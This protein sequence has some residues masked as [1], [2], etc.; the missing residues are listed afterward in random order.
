MERDTVFRERS[1]WT[2]TG[3]RKKHHLTANEEHGQQQSS[4]SHDRPTGIFLISI[5]L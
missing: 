4:S 5:S 3:K 1:T 2:V